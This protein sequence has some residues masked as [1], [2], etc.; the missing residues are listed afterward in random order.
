MK[1]LKISLFLAFTSSLNAGIASWYGNE[2]KGELMA[3]GKPFEPLAY[4]CASW[5]YPLGT[6]LLVTNKYNGKNVLVQVT[7]RGP[8]KRLKREIDLSLGAFQEIGDPDLGLLD[9][10]VQRLFVGRFN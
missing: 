2:L 10:T 6:F 4:T 8:N 5:Y 9:V 3:N 7:D 1:I